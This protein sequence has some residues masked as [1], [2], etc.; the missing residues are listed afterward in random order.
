MLLKLPTS[1][2]LQGIISA[3]MLAALL[4]LGLGHAFDAVYGSSAGAINA[5]FFLSGQ[6]NGLRIYYDDLPDDR[7]M[8]FR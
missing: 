1:F 3:G 5:A 4:D 6:K 2:R 8:D 7:F